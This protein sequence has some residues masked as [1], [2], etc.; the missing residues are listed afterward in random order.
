MTAAK[1]LLIFTMER[2]RCALLALATIV[3][4]K[5]AAV[6]LFAPVAAS[7]PISPYVAVAE[8]PR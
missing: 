6:A 5:I 1:A 4:L 3:L 8:I 2:V 7:A